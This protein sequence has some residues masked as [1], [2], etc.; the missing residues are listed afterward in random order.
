M[1]VC[2]SAK[3]WCA[4]ACGTP[5]RWLALPVPSWPHTRLGTLR[6]KGLILWHCRYP[7]ELLKWYK[8]LQQPRLWQPAEEAYGHTAQCCL[9]YEVAFVQVEQPPGKSHFRWT[10]ALGSPRSQLCHKTDT[11]LL[12]VF[13]VSEDLQNS[14]VEN[15]DFHQTWDTWTHLTISVS[16]LKVS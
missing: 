3:S 13:A 5:D 8:M 15:Q 11:P 6:L 9:L 16:A 7:P 14:G 4:D 2:L 10:E 12:T 1:L